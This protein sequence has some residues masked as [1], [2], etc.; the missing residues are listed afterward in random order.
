M[1]D[2]EQSRPSES[3]TFKVTVFGPVETKVVAF[4]TLRKMGLHLGKSS[5]SFYKLHCNIL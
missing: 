2:F 4:W 3:V 5:T 1:L